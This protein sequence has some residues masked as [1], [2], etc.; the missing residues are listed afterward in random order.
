MKISFNYKGIDTL[1]GCDLMGCGN[2]G[3]KRG[4]RTHKGVDLVALAG[5]LIFAPFD[6]EV[7]K[8]G[9]VYAETD[10]FKYI[11]FKGT[12]LLMFH[13][14]RIMYLDPYIPQQTHMVKVGEKMIKGAPLG[15]VQNIAN[16]HGGGMKNHIH[17]ECK[18]MGVQANPEPFI[19][20]I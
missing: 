10:L 6:L 20:T 1:R 16:Y 14:F 15:N 7:T 17:V 5:E 9:Q 18:I 8:I 19:N 13:R 11:E 12:G 2:Y 3:A 4:N